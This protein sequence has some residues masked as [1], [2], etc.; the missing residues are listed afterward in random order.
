MRREIRSTTDPKAPAR[1]KADN[2]TLWNLK[3]RA[4]YVRKESDEPNVIRVNLQDDTTEA[5][6][7]GGASVS[8]Q[9][10]NLPAA[11][12]A[13]KDEMKFWLRSKRGFKL[14]GRQFE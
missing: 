1:L 8:I 9:L 6:I 13:F 14:A 11:R 3:S 4:M 5:R 2:L 10:Y 12:A 7:K